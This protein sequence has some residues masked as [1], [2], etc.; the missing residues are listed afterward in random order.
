MHAATLVRLRP[1]AYHKYSPLQ[2]VLGS[3]PNISYLRIFGCSIQV[4]I[5]PS[6]RSKMGPQHWLGIYVDFD[7]PSLIHYLEPLTSDVFTARYP[8]CHFDENIFPP[9]GEKRYISKRET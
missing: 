3:Q 6:H 5:P 4:L 7:S 2:L 9:F 8:D 1:T